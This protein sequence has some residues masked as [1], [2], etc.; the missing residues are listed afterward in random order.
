MDAARPPERDPDLNVLGAPLRLCC[1]D[2]VTGF[3][4]TG[5][6]QTSNDDHGRHVVCAVMTD[7]FL[8]FSQSMGN[9]LST[10]R[11]E[12]GFPGLTAGDQWCL[13]ASRWREALDAGVAPKVVL[14]A[15]HQRALDYVEL[16]DLAEHAIDT[17]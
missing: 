9:D 1:A 15:T 8:A 4:R 6:C 13:C 2:P 7:E 10:P 12:M 3:F 5:F 17:A 16:A 14:A 11:P